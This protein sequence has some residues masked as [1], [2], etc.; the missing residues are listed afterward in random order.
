MGTP[1]CGRLTDEKATVMT[2]EE[3]EACCN[4]AFVLPSHLLCQLSKS[5][6][7]HVKSTGHDAFVVS[8]QQQE[9]P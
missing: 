1:L 8:Q 4:V 9:Q 7:C 2:R 3:K 6:E 5:N